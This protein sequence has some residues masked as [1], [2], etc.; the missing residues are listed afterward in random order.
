MTTDLFEPYFFVEIDEDTADRRLRELY[1]KGYVL[2]AA[3]PRGTLGGNIGNSDGIAQVY[4]I[5]YI[6]HRKIN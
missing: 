2:V 5:K 1:K 3:V 6:L 4:S